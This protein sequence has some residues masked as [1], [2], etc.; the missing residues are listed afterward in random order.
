MTNGAIFDFLACLIITFPHLPQILGYFE[1]GEL[2][3]VL[4]LG[5]VQCFSSKWIFM[6]YFQTT[7]LLFGQMGQFI[8]TFEQGE[9]RVDSAAIL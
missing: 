4:V 8:R 7:G 5:K 1:V 3:E 9:V 6:K 2:P